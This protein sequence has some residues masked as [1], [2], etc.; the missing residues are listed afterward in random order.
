MERD[1][2]KRGKKK[3]ETPQTELSLEHRST[4][5]N[6]LQPQKIRPNNCTAKV[7]GVCNV[8]VA[9]PKCITPV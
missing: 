3:V 4:G 2:G 9:K 7:L 6:V 5:L 8:H 1:E